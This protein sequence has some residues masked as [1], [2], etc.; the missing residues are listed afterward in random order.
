MVKLKE[1][2]NML[3]TYL[4]KE[5]KNF[6]LNNQGL[7]TSLDYMGH[8]QTFRYAL[9]S[10]S[11]NELIV[12]DTY[13]SLS[14][15][16]GKVGTVWTGYGCGFSHSDVVAYKDVCILCG[17]NNHP[18]LRKYLFDETV[19]PEV[20]VSTLEKG[21]TNLIGIKKTKSLEN[22]QRS[23]IED[24]LKKSFEERLN[25]IVLQREMEKERMKINLELVK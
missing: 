6:L 10:I 2:L 17:Q 7:I 24:Y 25:E 22:E 23:K 12:C 13:E 16:T 9:K 8:K 20:V 19:G 11:G 15:N 5:T 1:I 3:T 21:L 18:S 4:N 14:M